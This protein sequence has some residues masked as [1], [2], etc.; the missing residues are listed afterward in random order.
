MVSN[1]QD[2]SEAVYLTCI[3]PS[4]VL[5]LLG[6]H[7]ILVKSLEIA[8]LATVFSIATAY[9]IAYTVSFKTKLLQDEALIE[10]FFHSLIVGF[11][12]V[13]CALILGT[14]GAFFLTKVNFPGK[15]VFRAMVLLPYILPPI[16]IGLTID[17][18]PHRRRPSSLYRFLR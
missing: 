10:A 4:S 13:F 17:T 18:R 15:G 6:V 5:R 2:A 11:I 16:I 12:S 8:S 9:P 3:Q 7:K 1:N 14:A